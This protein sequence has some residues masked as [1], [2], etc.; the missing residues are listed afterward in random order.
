M[1]IHIHADFL[2]KIAVISCVIMSIYV[3]N[4]QILILGW[5]CFDAINRQRGTL[6]VL[7]Y[8]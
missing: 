2:I 6:V 1:E 5:Q 7:S 4:P 3:R 8:I